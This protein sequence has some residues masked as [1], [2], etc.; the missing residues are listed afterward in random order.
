[1][2][3]FGL[4]N[5]CRDETDALCFGALLWVLAFDAQISTPSHTPIRLTPSEAAGFDEVDGVKS[6][7][8]QQP[9]RVLPLLQELCRAEKWE[10]KAPSEF[11]RRYPIT[12]VMTKTLGAL[13]DWA[14]ADFKY[15]VNALFAA[16]IVAADAH[17]QNTPLTL[18]LAS[19]VPRAKKVIECFPFFVEKQLIMSTVAAES[20]TAL[21]LRHLA[22]VSTVHQ[23]FVDFP[24]S[25]VILAKYKSLEITWSSCS[26]VLDLYQR[27]AALVLQNILDRLK[28][29]SPNCD[30]KLPLV[31]SLCCTNRTPT[32]HALETWEVPLLESTDFC[33]QHIDV[34]SPLLQHC[35][36][37]LSVLLS[38]RLSLIVLLRLKQISRLLLPNPVSDSSLSACPK[39][40]DLAGICNGSWYERRHSVL[41]RLATGFFNHTKF[42]PWAAQFVESLDIAFDVLFEK[43][44]FQR[45]GRQVVT[46]SS[47]QLS[48]D[49]TLPLWSSWTHWM[50]LFLHI[51]PGLERYYGSLLQVDSFG[52]HLLK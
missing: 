20:V 8:L 52:R 7:S 15:E 31:N 25:N 35:V 50:V 26:G 42:A 45:L 28:L 24:S 18:Q 4:R 34:A 6:L 9:N 19:V 17:R 47:L 46:P 36:R 14:L 2:L 40:L 33:Q 16:S 13:F 21:V 11:F 22:D 1:M 39:S 43:I 3:D 32:I 41:L 44:E 5:V 49:A 51:L 30:Q 48:A 12:R 38:G 10:E 29:F 27:C 23:Y 37:F